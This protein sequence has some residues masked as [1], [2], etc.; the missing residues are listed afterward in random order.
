MSLGFFSSDC[1]D[2]EVQ[3]D[4]DSFMDTVGNLLGEAHCC[5][6]SLNVF[7]ASCSR[8]SIWEKKSKTERKGCNMTFYDNCRNLARSLAK[9]DCQ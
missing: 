2:E 1:E 7:F 6:T 8:V 4:A 5:I 3:F 9:F